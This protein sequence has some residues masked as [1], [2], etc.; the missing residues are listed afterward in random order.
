MKTPATGSMNCTQ[1]A[2]GRLPSRDGGYTLD[3]DSWSLLHRDGHQEGVARR[4]QHPRAS[5]R[6]IG[7]S[8]PVWRNPKWW[9]GSGCAKAT[10]NARRTCRSSW[11]SCWNQLPKPIR[12]GRV[13]ADA[14]FY[15]EG[16]VATA[17]T[18]RAGVCHRHEA[19]SQMAEMLPPMRMRPGRRRTSRASRPGD[20]REQ[21][22]RRLIMLRH[23]LS[24]RP[25]A[26]G[27]ELLQVPGYR[28]QALVTNLPAQL[29]CGGGVA[30]L[31]WPGRQR[32]PDPGTGRSIWRQ[33][34]VL[35]EVLGHAS[36][37][38]S[39]P[40]GPTTFA[41][42]CNGSWGC[43][44]KCGCKPCAGAGF[45][46]RACGAGPKANPPS[47]WRFHG[48]KERQWWIKVAEKL[49]DPLPPLN[50]NAVEWAKSLEKYLPC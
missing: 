12:I 9:P 29:E 25:E 17:R 2:L 32:E 18:A 50:G 34:L 6:V 36:G 45:A 28:F 38:V 23:R 33:G 35:S 24:E 14:G 21:I 39:L 26:L 47:S 27:K 16:R 22:G 44:K 20:C 42:C 31:Q 43:W 30:L 15:N 4:S 5:N 7:R 19:L 49:R 48:Q 13:R 40:S 10:R 11:E 37:V 1:W 8:S 46:G 3:L 41:C